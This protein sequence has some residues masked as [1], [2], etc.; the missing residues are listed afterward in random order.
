[1][2]Q[3][4][5]VHRLPLSYRWRNGP[6]DG[7]IEPQR[8]ND[9]NRDDDLIGLRLLS[10]QGQS[11]WDIMQTIRLALAEIQLDCLVLEWEGEPCLFVHRQDEYTTTCRLK[12]Y[13]V[14]IAEPFTGMM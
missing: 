10:H 2:L 8:L 13:G 14:G 3:N 6:A 12:N 11:A 1:M 9:F 7:V 5:V 4:S